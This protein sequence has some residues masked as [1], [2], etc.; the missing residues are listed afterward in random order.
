MQLSDLF[1][2]KPK[3]VTVRVNKPEASTG[4]PPSTVAPVPERKEVPDGL[5]VKCPKCAQIIY[6]K[7][8][9]AN[10]GLCQRCSYHFRLG[11]WERVNSLADDGIFEETNAQLTS[12]DPLEFAGYIAKQK[13]ARA[14]SGL[15]E[16]VVTGFCTISDHAVGLGVMDFA[17]MGGSMGSVVGE[18][19]TRLIEEAI[20]RRVPVILFCTSGGARMQEGI[21]SLMQMAKTSAALGRL[22]SEG[23]LYVCVLTDPTTA[24]VMASFAQ[25]GDIILA[26]PDSLIGFT[27][28]RVI[29]QTLRQKLPDG[30]QRSEFV[31]EHGFIDMIVPR[32]DMKR[33]LST[34]LELHRPSET[35]GNIQTAVR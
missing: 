6:I 12:A 26:E 33:T 18:K 9:A 29:E 20:S 13:A 19:I 1:R 2:P 34:I 22:D 31:M 16:G 15:N 17:F 14:K 28:A 23:L 32:N 8:L 24:G 35:P 25:L 10:L 3:Y 4:T 21:L 11:A 30:F 7:E 5:W 27:G